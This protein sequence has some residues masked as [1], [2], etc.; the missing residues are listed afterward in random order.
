M[1][2]KLKRSEKTKADDRETF[3][4]V[5]RFSEADKKLIQTICPYDPRRRGKTR[6]EWFAELTPIV[7]GLKLTK[8]RE[9][10]RYPMRLELPKKLVMALQD[11]NEKL[12]EVG[13]KKS[14]VELLILAAKEYATQN[15]IELDDEHKSPQPHSG[16]VEK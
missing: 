16:E 2:K 6:L 13:I 5:M 1:A 9:P 3:F 11:K 7:R 14:M 8:P 15:G 10:S 4:Y 12:E